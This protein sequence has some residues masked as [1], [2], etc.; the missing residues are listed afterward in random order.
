M[1]QQPLFDIPK[2]SV[3]EL[4]GQELLVT[5]LERAGY[6]VECQDTGECLTLSVARIEAAIRGRDCEVLEPADAERRKALLEFTGGYHRLEQFSAPVR[7]EAQRRLA[8]VLAMDELAAN[9]Y[10]ITQRSMSTHGEHRNALILRANKIAPQLKFIKKGSEKKPKPLFPIA[11]GRT[12]AKFRDLYHRYGGNPVVLADREHLKGY[13]TSRLVPWQ[14]RF[15]DFALNHWQD[16]RK[17]QLAPLVRDAAKVFHRTAAEMAQCINFPSVTTL[18]QRAKAF[19]DVATEFGR[20][21]KRQATNKKG[22]G[23]TDVRALRYGEKFEWDQVYLSIF[24]NGSGVVQAEPIDPDDVPK[25]LADNE[26]RRCWLH[27]ILDV[28]TREALGW[29]ISETAD[30]DHSLALL[31]MATRDKTKEKVRYGCKEDPAPPVRLGLGLADNGS[32]TRNGR[33]YAA[34]LGMGMT[35]M[36]GRAYHATDKPY[37]ERFFGTMQGQIL[38]FLPGY[39][40]SYPGEL[41]GYNPKPSAEV[42]HD[43]LMGVITRYLVDEYPFQ[44]HYGTGMFGATPRQKREEALKRYGRIKSPS[45]HERCLYLG[46]K[47]RASTTSEGVKAFNIPFNSSELQKFADGKSKS[48]TIH[49]DP[50]DLRTVL[51]TAE[52]LEA[53]LEAQLRMTLFKDQTLEEAIE[54]ME[55]A[56]KANP[57]LRALHREQLEEAKTRRVRDSCYFKDSRDWSCPRFSGHSGGCGLSCDELARRTH[58]QP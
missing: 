5:G 41:T 58:L 40:G 54:L 36:T 51:I 13:R 32:A 3:L 28:A 1:T 27:V 4:D 21:G 26:I 47:I 20:G 25:K 55:A 56:T 49:L 45:Q 22:A 15:I 46:T 19:S 39:T 52:G 29:V 38:N 31:R 2:G 16:K 48:V 35:V 7:L 18:R 8:L 24:T 34:Q 53:V 17:P 11:E 33:V 10:K 14:E 50:D 57:K 42:S 43:Q 23:S 30:S 44:P 6:A 37:I 9:G 12:L